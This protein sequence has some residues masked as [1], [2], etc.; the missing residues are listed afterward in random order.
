MKVI[1]V[2][3]D[4]IMP[5][6]EILRPWAFGGALTSDMADL[7]RPNME[8]FEVDVDG[9]LITIKKPWGREYTAI[10]VDGKVLIA[11]DIAILSGLERKE[12]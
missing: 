8:L 9:R 10:E 1:L 7:N 4:D 5:D 6:G 12:I 3:G 2:R 11:R